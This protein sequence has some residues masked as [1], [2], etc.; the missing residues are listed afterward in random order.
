MSATTTPAA[1]AGAGITDL[2]GSLANLYGTVTASRNLIKADSGYLLLCNSASAIV[3]TIPNDAAGGWSGIESMAAYQASTGAVSFAAGAG[4]SPIRGT[5][6]TPA[7][8]LTSGVMRVGA[9]EWAYI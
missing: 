7:Q 5:A 9:N 3:L 6:P 2:A 8:Y 1:G 4:V